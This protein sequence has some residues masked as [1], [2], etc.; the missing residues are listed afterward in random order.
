MAALV[1]RIQLKHYIS[2]GP[3]IKR[4][5]GFYVVSGSPKLPCLIN[6]L[7][8]PHGGGLRG[9]GEEGP[10][11][12]PLLTVPTKLP[13]GVTELSWIPLSI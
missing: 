11:W 1:N 4:I 12:P 2:L 3:P 8:R 10:S 6:L 7:E 9:H 13:G 5:D